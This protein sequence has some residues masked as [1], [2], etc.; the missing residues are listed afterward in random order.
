[1]ELFSEKKDL[2]KEIVPSFRCL[3]IQ[4]QSLW[5]LSLF[6]ELFSEKKDLG[7]EIVP[8]FR[9]L[10]IQRQSLWVLSLFSEKK[11]LGKEIVPSFGCFTK[12]TKM[13]LEMHDDP[14]VLR[15]C[16]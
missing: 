11:D 9:C 13:P 7:K 5:V 1:L 14:L 12:L 10:T 6:W 3:T 15:T 2:G 16:N 8:S 4:R